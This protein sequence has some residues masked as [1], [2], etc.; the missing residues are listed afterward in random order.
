MT[1]DLFA[2]NNGR[3]TLLTARDIVQVGFRHKMVLL[4]IFGLI[5]MLA[6]IYAFAVPPKYEAETKILVRQ[7]RLDP[8]VSPTANAPLIIRQPLTEEELN[9]EVEILLSDDVLH[10]VVTTS[11][12]NRTEPVLPHPFRTAGNPHARMGA[13]VSQL[14]SAL[15]VIPLKKTSVIKVSYQQ[16]NA[17][18]A[19]QVL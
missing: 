6:F 7:G 18:Q 11:G 9:S 3:Q 14:K 8:V 10:Q 4:A 13:A 12:L 15:K 2:P 1:D 5:S 19:A 16:R 17:Q